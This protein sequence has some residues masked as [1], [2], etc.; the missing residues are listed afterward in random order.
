MLVRRSTC[1]ECLQK[2]SHFLGSLPSRNVHTSA[3]G[4]ATVAS[5]T[6]GTSRAYAQFGLS[7]A[8]VLSES[9]CAPALARPSEQEAGPNGCQDQRDCQIT[10]L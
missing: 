7:R 2:R 1:E 9:G 6:Q 8:L 10:R 4:P 5:T 3:A